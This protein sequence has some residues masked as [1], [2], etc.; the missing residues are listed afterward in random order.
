[1]PVLLHRAV[2]EVALVVQAHGL[3]LAGHSMIVVHEDGQELLYPLAAPLVDGRGLAHHFLLDGFIEKRVTHL[4]L[5]HG[6][7]LLYGLVVTDE[8]IEI[9]VVVL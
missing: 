6:I 9:F 1:M 8:G 4:P 7:A 5:D 3:V 2:V